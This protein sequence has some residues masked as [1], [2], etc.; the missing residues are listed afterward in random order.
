MKIIC[1]I[2]LMLLI[3]ATSYAQNKLHTVNAV[4]GDESFVQTFGTKPT[5]STNE[6]LRIQ[7]HLMFVEKE[8][9]NKNISGLTKKQKRNRKKAL[10]I[11]HEYWLNGIFPSNYDYPEERKAMLY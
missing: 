9:R 4:I 10:D 7:T 3:A 5:Q 11:L 2:S 1:T 6:K 8:L